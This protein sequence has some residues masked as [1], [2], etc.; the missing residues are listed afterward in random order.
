MDAVPS[1]T[2]PHLLNIMGLIDSV[3][4]RLR[5]WQDDVV[6][7]D[8]Q[9]R[10][11]LS[12]SSNVCTQAHEAATH[13]AAFAC[14]KCRV[15]CRPVHARGAQHTCRPSARS[16]ACSSAPTHR[17]RRPW[18]LQVITFVD[19]SCRLRPMVVVSLHL[20]MLQTAADR[21]AYAERCHCLW[22]RSAA[23]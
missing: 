18:R 17:W 13:V 3:C 11:Y 16:T 5:R 20:R 1:G 12:H 9:S 21:C 14:S 23:G 4:A 7:A 19:C 10:Q 2:R 15:P 8:L 22:Q 6:I